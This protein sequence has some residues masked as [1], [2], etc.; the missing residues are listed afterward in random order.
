MTHVDIKEL[1]K[2]Y[3]AGIFDGE[4]NIQRD[5][6]ILHVSIA[7]V[8]YPFLQAITEEY[9][10]HVDKNGDCWKWCLGKASE[11]LR[12]FTA[13]QPYS[14]LY[15][16]VL[17]IVIELCSQVA[18]LGTNNRYQDVKVQL[19]REKLFELFEAANNRRRFAF[20]EKI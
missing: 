16:E 3:L 4:G 5:R 11:Q 15:A 18:K 19:L 1:R 17:P 6:M 8:N 20:R 12:F 9:N 13:I 14:I 7:Q 10:G 2:A